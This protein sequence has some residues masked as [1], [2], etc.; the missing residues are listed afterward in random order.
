MRVKRISASSRSGPVSSSSVAVAP[1]SVSSSSSSAT[2]GF[3][4]YLRQRHVDRV[5][6][7]EIHHQVGQ[8]HLVD[9]DQVHHAH[10]LG[11][12]GRAGG[13]GLGGLAHAVLDAL[14]E[15]DLALAR[16]QLDRAHLAHVHAH[17]VGGAAEFALDRRHRDLLGLF[18]GLVLVFRRRRL[19][20][21]QQGFRIR[22]L[23]VHLDAHVV[24]HA[25]DRLDLVGI[26]DVLG[27]VVVDFPVREETL[28]LALDDQLLELY[29]LLFLIHVFV[30]D[31]DTAVKR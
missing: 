22:R 26:V 19:G 9:L 7:D 16:E 14:G 11:D 24:D 20:L 23:V 28:F 4:R 6:V 3:R 25:H 29:A 21:E 5:R 2:A 27:Q 30:P 1:A 31:A 10:D 18:G 13:D 8:A 15:V 12:R 17:R